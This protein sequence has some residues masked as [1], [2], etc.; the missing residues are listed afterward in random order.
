MRPV[1][2]AERGRQASKQYLQIPQICNLRYLGKIKVAKGPIG[3]L[4]QDYIFYFIF[5]I[6]FF[7]IFIIID[8]F[9]NFT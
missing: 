1:R 4:I 2:A 7:S 3:K 5:I 8:L 6:F 9:F